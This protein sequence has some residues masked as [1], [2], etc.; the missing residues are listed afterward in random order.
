MVELK[1]C[2]TAPKIKENTT[3]LC[4]YFKF[5]HNNIFTYINELIYQFLKL[6]T[7]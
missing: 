4:P 2:P 5:I 6:Q 7:V 1:I 3:C